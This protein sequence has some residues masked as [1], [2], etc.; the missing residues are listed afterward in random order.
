MGQIQA[1]Q[2]GF[3]ALAHHLHQFFDEI[4]QCIVL[5]IEDANGA[6]GGAKSRVVPK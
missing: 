4:C 1:L 6:K 2:T 3:N 5:A